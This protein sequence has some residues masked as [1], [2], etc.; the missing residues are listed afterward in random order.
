MDSS[1]VFERVIEILRPYAKNQ[2]G[3]ADASHDTHLLDDLKINSA[4]LV[5][6]VLAFEDEFDIGI[7]D[8][9]LEEVSTV[10]SAV[11]LIMSA[12]EGLAAV[13]GA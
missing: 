12:R 10:G 4:R 1:E 6:I 3:I 9:D 11:E 13:A 2:A 8:D 7:S 5:D